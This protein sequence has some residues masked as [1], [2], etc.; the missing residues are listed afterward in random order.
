MA[1][2]QMA[3]IKNNDHSPNGKIVSVYYTPGWL[4]SL[5]GVQSFLFL[6]LDCRNVITPVRNLRE[7]SLIAV[8]FGS[9]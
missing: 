8:R 4:I 9:C 1:I 6:E 2:L 5:H 3:I 7:I